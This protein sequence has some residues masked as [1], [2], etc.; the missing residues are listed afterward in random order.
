MSSSGLRF[1]RPCLNLELTAS[2]KAA[3][4]S[5]YTSARCLAAKQSKPVDEVLQ[6]GKAFRIAVQERINELDAGGALKYP[7]IKSSEQALSIQEFVKKHETGQIDEE[8][9]KL[10]VRAR[11]MSVRIA[12]KGLVFVDLVQDGATL[13]A[14]LS[15]NSMEDSSQEKVSAT[16]FIKFY[17]LLR[18][19]D[20][21]CECACE[22]IVAWLTRVA[23]D[24]HMYVTERGE[25]SIRA[26][27]LPEILTPCLASLP[28]TLEDR[29]TRVRNRHVDL[30]VNRE[31]VETL[32]LR[33]HIIQYLRDFLLKDQFLEVQTP[34][35]TDKA[36]G[37]VAKPFTTFATEFPDKQLA[38]RIA[39][40]IW[41]KR[42]VIGGLDR[43]F[44]IGPAFRNEG[45]DA[46]H[47]PEFTTCEFYKSFA[48]LEDLKHMTWLMFTGLA[49]HLWELHWDEKL[50]SLP[51]VDI[52]HSRMPFWE[53]SFIRTIEN[54]LGEKLP[55]LTDLD[56]DEKL[57][58]L[59]QKHYLPLPTSRTLPRLLDKLCGI[60]IEPLCIE[61]TFITHH[62]SCMSPL[63]KSFVCP[64]TNQLVSARA[65]LF[66]QN[67]E[68]ANMYEEE[69][70]PFAQR[71]K[72][73]EQGRYRDDE[74]EM[75]VDESYCEALEYGLP[76][77][78]GWGMGVDR[79]VMLF[80]SQKR[81]GDVL[82]FGSLRNVVNLGSG[83]RKKEKEEI[84]KRSESS[85]AGD[86]AIM[87]AA[88]GMTDGFGLSREQVVKEDE[89]ASGD[90]S[91]SEMA[92]LE[93]LDVD[94]PK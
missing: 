60:Y 66:V 22:C 85:D 46:T 93:S 11:V 9:E 78:G 58:A 7:R 39:P 48:N 47:N 14:V 86:A 94:V 53:M 28:R 61:P 32:R 13:Q 56:A 63:A 62:P 29:E 21:I 36:S 42:L 41:L 65:E 70:S 17:H 19:G 16:E 64:D 74:G 79:L 76:P 75:E 52:A 55:I 25:L 84:A 35:I 73:I 77:T 88:M 69:N 6:T 89:G 12:S 44:E 5:F 59:F 20:I 37:A 87:G 57:I 68:I 51:W 24:G 80:S 15:R 90:E 26:A 1:L 83:Q 30:L 45:L 92:T 43:V 10:V 8:S 54:A 67:R 4:R 33:S 91:V 38:L 27:K 40:E 3:Y 72:F 23:V 50:P 82:A 2:T 31:A 81:I 71:E 34:L 18:R 49:E